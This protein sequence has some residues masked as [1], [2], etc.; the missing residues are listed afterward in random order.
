[1]LDKF[2]Y[3]FKFSFN[4]W[5][6]VKCLRKHFYRVHKCSSSTVFCI[7]LCCKQKEEVNTAASLLCRQNFEKCKCVIIIVFFFY[8]YYLVIDLAAPEKKK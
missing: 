8:Y 7:C 3:F 5:M 1:M 6:K 4:T 2:G